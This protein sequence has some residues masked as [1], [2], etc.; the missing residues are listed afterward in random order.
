[1]LCI[2]PAAQLVQGPPPEIGF[3]HGLEMLYQFIQGDFAFI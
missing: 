3:C 2:W 1:V